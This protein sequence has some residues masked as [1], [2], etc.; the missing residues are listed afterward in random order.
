MNVLV[1]NYGSDLYGANRILL[2][3]IEMLNPR[4]VVLLVGKQGPLTDLINADPCYRHVH[5][6]EAKTIPVV[7]RKMNFKNI[8]QLVKNINNF[9]KAI[10]KI[11]KEFSI[12][13]V[14]VNTLSN[15]I[16]I[17]IFKKNNLKV[18]VHV[19][20]I[21]ENHKLSTRIINYHSIKWADKIIAVSK[22]V[23]L[24]LKEVNKKNNIVTVLNGIK[25]MYLQE[26]EKTKPAIIITLFGRIKPEKGI[27]YFLEAIALLKEKISTN[28]KFIIAGS[29][30]PGGEHYVEQLKKDIQNHSSK[31]NIEFRSFISDIKGLLNSSDIIV[32][33][34]LMKDPFPTTILEAASAGKP[35]IATNTGG[36]VQS[37]KNEITGFLISPSDTK[38]FAD[39]LQKLI[40]SEKLRDTMGKAAR[41]FYLEKFTID[42]FRKDFL[43]VVESFE[44]DCNVF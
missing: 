38:Q 11:K 3:T 12:N 15:F 25:D 13:W 24:N 8:L 17:R 21:L 1:V 10:K 35:V 7:F 16:A 22:P 32:V 4:K 29:A 5:I 27:W 37:V 31:S 23:E 6:I 28:A 43:E 18:L 39:Y 33:P 14:Y 42:I 26:M 40:E 36:A 19:H 20:E 41:A 2:Q 30:A 9:N 44:K 34:S